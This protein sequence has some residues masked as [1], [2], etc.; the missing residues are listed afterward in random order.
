MTHRISEPHLNVADESE[1]K[2]AIVDKHWDTELLDNFE[3]DH[4][5]TPKHQKVE[6]DHEEPHH[7]EPH[8]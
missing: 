6:L 1:G 5:M 3:D 4:E 7:K 2:T 8:H